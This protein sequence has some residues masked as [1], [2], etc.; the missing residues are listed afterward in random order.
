MCNSVKA[1]IKAQKLEIH[2]IAFT[3]QLFLD[4]QPLL[5]AKPMVNQSILTLLTR[6]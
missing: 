2:W 3:P 6:V 5:L 4:T 1:Q